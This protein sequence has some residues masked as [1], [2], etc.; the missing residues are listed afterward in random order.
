MEKL[1][2]VRL[3]AQDRDKIHAS[4]ELLKC[5]RCHDEVNLK[6][7]SPMSPPERLEV[8]EKM[9]QKPDSGMAPGES[10]EI[11]RAYEKIQGF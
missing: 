11:L 4:L 9:R 6:K 1:P 3:S 8:V 5:V 7:L 2:D 10:A